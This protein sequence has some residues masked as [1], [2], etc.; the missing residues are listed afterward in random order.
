MIYIKIITKKIHKF[1]VVHMKSSYEDAAL[2]HAVAS[3]GSFS[4]YK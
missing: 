1:V 3:V 4:L 2:L